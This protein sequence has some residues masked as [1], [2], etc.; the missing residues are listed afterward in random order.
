MPGC[1]V[2][3]KAGIA[4]PAGLD[5]PA[6]EAEELAQSG[7][8]SWTRRRGGLQALFLNRGADG[9]TCAAPGRVRLCFCFC[10]YFAAW[11]QAAQRNPVLP[12]SCLTVEEYEPLRPYEDWARN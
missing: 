3:K 10:F 7:A 12:T 9:Y 6:P 2:V 4:G 1:G 8:T 5:G 11:V